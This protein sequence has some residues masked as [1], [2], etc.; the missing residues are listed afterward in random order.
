MPRLSIWM[1][2]T[3]LSYLLLGF[4]FGALLLA[5][6]GI[7]LHPMLWRLLPLH[8]E[9]LLI[10]WTLQLAMGVAYWILP[11]FLSKRGREGLAWVAYL[12][13]N[14]GLCCIVLSVVIPTWGGVAAVGRG[15]E[16]LAAIA[17]AL[18]AWP[19]IKPMSDITTP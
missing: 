2:R 5:H 19:R 11:R 15:L 16:A 4:T 7:G 1:V 13:L 8:I 12:L 6:K 18:H 17:F 14:S 10:G 3:A 9:F